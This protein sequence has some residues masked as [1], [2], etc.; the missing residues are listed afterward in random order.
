M[1]HN[2]DELYQGVPDWLGALWPDEIA[3]TGSKALGWLIWEWT[4][5]DE[6]LLSNNQRLEGEA[7]ERNTDKMIIGL[8][9]NWVQ[10]L[11]WG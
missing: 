11:K 8:S 6:D 10:D 2:Q 1:S 4:F 3:E 5:G 9:P 7:E